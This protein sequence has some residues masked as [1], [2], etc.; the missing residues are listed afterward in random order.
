MQDKII[1]FPATEVSLFPLPV[2]LTPLI[3]REHELLELH[4]LLLRPDVRLLTL[5]GTGGVGK[6]RLA[7]EVAR[8]AQDE[9]T[10]GVCFVSLASLS[11]AEQVIP[12]I[13]RTLG[14]RE[15]REQ[16]L[17]QLQTYVRKQHML[18]VLD[19]FEQVMAA[20]RH[21]IALLTTC[22]DL[23]LLITSRTGL[24]FP[25]GYDYSV[26]P[27]S[28][29]DT[30]QQF[31]EKTVAQAAAVQLF[32]QRASA[33]LPT[34]QLT[35]RN[36][37]LIA[38][39]CTRLEGLPLALELAAMR[40]RLLPLQALL[41]R[42]ESPLNL[43]A[44]G[45]HGFPSRQQTIRA[46]IQWSYDLLDHLERR[47]FRLCSVFVGGFTLQAVEA[48]YLALHKGN[49][50]EMGTVLTGI[51]SLV[52]KSLLQQPILEEETEEPRLAML[53]IVR[54]YGR[55]LLLERG[56]LEAVRRAHATFFLQ[57]TE[58]AVKQ[59]SGI[60]QLAR[61]H[62]NIRAALT[63]MLEEAHDDQR[64]Q[65]VEMAL[66]LGI[67]LEP[68]WKMRG[69]LSEGWSMM[70]RALA[71]SE[72]V[73]PEVRARTLIT[74]AT[75]I[76]MLGN[77][78]HAETLLEQSLALCKELG[79][80]RSYAYCLR[81]LGWIAQQK[82]NFP[83][84]QVLYNEGLALFQAQGDQQGIAS[85]LSNIGL[86]MQSQ[87]DYKQAC[88][89]F[90]KSLAIFRAL[91]AAHEIARQL[92][93]LA[94]LR[95]VASESFS[96]TEVPSLLDECAALAQEVGDQRLVAERGCT[97]GF[98][99]FIQGD[100]ETAYQLI[101][102]GVAFYKRDGDRTEIGT[103]LTILG[104][105]VAVQGDYHAAEALFRESLAIGYAINDTLTMTLAVGGMIQLAVAQKQGDRAV[106]LCGAAEKLHEA[107]VVPLPSFERA[108]YQHAITTLRPFFDKQAFATLWAEGRAMSL[109]A[110]SAAREAA[111]PTVAA[112]AQ[113]AAPCQQAARKGSTYPDGLSAREV[114]VLRYV[115]HGYSDAQI[116]KR[117]TISPRTVNSHLTSIYRKI[118]VANRTA[119]TSYA[120]DHQL[121]G[122]DFECD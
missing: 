88:H 91:G 67:L 37:P 63:W 115:A 110:I 70:E 33:M 51:E 81:G 82:G 56:E 114:E 104:R 84:A 105:I 66:R 77:H 57:F 18:L 111:S 10:D 71:Q 90:S 85:L 21:L 14:L 29:P 58:E 68:F 119:A 118:H 11:D 13:T 98:L 5:T 23:H 100:M 60:K 7:I 122:R 4:H 20:A 55:E 17:E 35:E 43:L 42:L 1:S 80:T 69:Y 6:T 27:L 75:L 25:G 12:T 31:D 79:D 92:C 39:I 106:R 101:S 24:S 47:L 19:N 64:V 61:N 96:V 86:L 109:Q 38:A 120:F 112:A 94:L 97:L 121:A 15:T 28:V 9:F 62:Q 22:P 102:K 8:S 54:E 40:I 65:R 117:L 52:N 76:D 74:A 34:F 46:T 16:P 87:Q 26:P 36:A 78:N 99:A 44:Q 95:C 113:E 108:A 50:T 41:K 93:Q 83:R 48:V 73:T 3:G 30:T 107:L 89:L 72:E 53:E 103:R 2:A 59:T 32:V 116:A 49:D 45:I